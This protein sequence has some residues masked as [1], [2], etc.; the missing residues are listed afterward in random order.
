MARS[1]VAMVTSGTAS[2]ECALASCPQVVCY[3]AVGWKWAHDIFLHILKIPY[4]SLPNLIA[5]KIDLETRRE[6]NREAIRTG[7]RGCVVPELLV[8]NC[9][10]GNLDR[11][12]SALIAD[13]PA[14]TRQLE[15]YRR[16]RQL[17]TTSEPAAYNTA[18]LIYSYT[19]AP[20][21]N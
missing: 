8:H 16:V 17:L 10:I 6:V 13:G 14:R 7:V 1:R 20:A 12:I 19:K 9:T 21:R 11:E 3:R 2:L 15:G 4:V 18:R 5:G